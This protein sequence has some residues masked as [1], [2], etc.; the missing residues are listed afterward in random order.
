MKGPG[1]L[2]LVGLVAA[3]LLV[4]G[5]A[6]AYRITSMRQALAEG[7]SGPRTPAAAAPVRITTIGM[8]APTARP[9]DRPSTRPSIE[10]DYPSDTPADPAPVQAPAMALSPGSGSPPAMQPEPPERALSIADVP[11]I[12]YTTSWCSVCKRAK[13]W[14]NGQGIA[15]DERDIESSQEYALTMRGLN[16]RGSIPTFDIDGDVMV[17]FSESDLVAMMQRAARRRAAR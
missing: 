10:R 1:R 5:G 3:A 17:G 13:A 2:R 8:S 14:M 7:A 16:P 9:V 15:Y 12:V 4:A 11:V 6:A